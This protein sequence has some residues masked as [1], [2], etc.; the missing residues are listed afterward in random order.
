MGSRIVNVWILLICL[1][2]PPPSGV[3]PHPAIN[4][5]AGPTPPEIQDPLGEATS[6]LLETLVLWGSIILQQISTPRPQVPK[7]TSKSFT[8]S[9]P[10]ISHF[11]PNQKHNTTPPLHHLSPSTKTPVFQQQ[12]QTASWLSAAERARTALPLAWRP[13][14]KIS[15][16]WDGRPSSK[17]LSQRS[18]GSIRTSN[19]CVPRDF[20]GKKIN[21]PFFSMLC[22]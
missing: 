9:L 6:S 13:S 11:P 16:A 4:F 21:T 12:Q 8:L 22:L 15:S 19:R 10:I 20:L 1:T 2:S 3:T 5:R 14:F 18:R 7:S 17:S